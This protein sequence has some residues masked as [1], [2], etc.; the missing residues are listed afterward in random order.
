MCFLQEKSICFGNMV[1]AD[2]VATDPSTLE[3]VQNWPAPT[4]QKDAQKFL[5]LANYYRR[6]I[7]D[8]AKVTKPLHKLTEKTT[9]LSGHLNVRILLPF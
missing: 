9:W 4:S 6:F 5:G 8:F 2:G 1:S 3:K 7:W